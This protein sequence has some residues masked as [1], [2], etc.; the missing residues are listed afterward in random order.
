[1]K[2]IPLSKLRKRL[3][4]WASRVKLLEERV[5]IT[6]HRVPVAA[7]VPMHEFEALEAAEKKELQYQEFLQARQLERFK[8]LK[9][10]LNR[11][12]RENPDPT[13]C[14]PTGRQPYLYRGLPH[15]KV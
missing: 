7:L 1:M 10:E 12:R 15:G 5:V 8:R 11:N 14:S 3:G 2:M 13:D 6:R 9:E 4:P